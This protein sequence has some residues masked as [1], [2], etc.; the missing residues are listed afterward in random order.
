MTI[1]E[2]GAIGEFVGSIAVLVT[3]IYLAVQIRQN[4]KALS[5]AS[6]RN[7]QNEYF[8]WKQ[9][10]L[11]DDVWK[12]SDS[13]LP[14]VISRPIV[15]G[16]FKSDVARN[17]VAAEFYE[18]ATKLVDEADEKFLSNFHRFREADAESK[19]GSEFSADQ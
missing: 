4:T 11:S 10:A 16:W 8:L 18:Y 7:R 19:L 14:G 9:G 3:L 12:A 6:I 5:A 15:K 1:A 13:I 17:V 2:L